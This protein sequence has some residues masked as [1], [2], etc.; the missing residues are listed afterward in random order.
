[1]PVYQ[2]YVEGKSTFFNQVFKARSQTV[3]K[4]YPTDEE[5]A[6]FVEPCKDESYLDYLD[7]STE[8]ARKMLKVDVLTLN[9]E[10]QKKILQGKVFT[11]L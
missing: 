7:V 11:R 5:K 4:H 2:I 6:A 1:M 3:F 8:N 10:D 9:L